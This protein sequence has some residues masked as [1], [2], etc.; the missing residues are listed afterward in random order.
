MLAQAQA[1]DLRS[2]KAVFVGLD[3]RKFFPPA[4]DFKGGWFNGKVA[5][6]DRNLRDRATQ[7]VF[8]LL[9]LIR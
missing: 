8:E 5:S 7:E 2:A 3:V 6:V 1:L 4:S 9:C